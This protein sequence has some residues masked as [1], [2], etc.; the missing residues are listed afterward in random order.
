MGVLAFF[1]AASFSLATAATAPKTGGTLRFSLEKDI[2]NVNPFERASSVNKDV[3]SL[4]FECLLTSDKDDNLR[5][6]LATAWEV[7]KKGDEYAF[8]LRK[9]VKFHNGKEM[10]AEDVL[11]SINYA[12]DPKNAAYGRDALLP[13]ASVSAAD[14]SVLRITLREPYVPF[15]A[16]LTS[17]Q[18]FPIVPQGS[19]PPERGKMALYPPGT[20]P[21]MMVDYKPNQV[22]AFKRFDQYW[23]KGLPY[24]EAVHFR[25]VED[26]TVRLTALR[27]G[28]FDVV[29]RVAYPEAI[30]IQKGEF[31]DISLKVADA[32]GYIAPV[33]NTERPPFDDPRLRRAAL[34]AIDKSKILDGVTWGLGA[35][36]DQRMHRESRWFVTLPDRK[37]DIEKARALLREAGYPNGIRIKGQVS[38][39]KRD[40]DV[41]QLL[42]SQLREANIQM[43]LEVRDFAKH[44]NDLRDGSFTLSMSAGSTNI[45]PDAVYYRNF[46]TEKTELRISNYPRYS[47]PRVDRLLE[48]GRREADFQRRH[49]IY[50]EVV[51][52]LLEDVPEIALGFTPYVFAFRSHVHGF[53][54]SPYGVFYYGLGGLAMTWMDR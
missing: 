16:T 26:A 1:L 22:I 42:Q 40:Q 20:G 53:D 6:S 44:M 3:G 46:H 32:S 7:S 47:N 14:A 18:T 28:D 29:E 54:V 35:V 9:G 23:Q 41:M 33:F 38:R 45:D 37:R 49:Q 36:G 12:R 19:V 25:P 34:Y 27:A 4:A 39:T 52:I 15:L 11:W 8:T 24:L 50:K 51:E 10:T 31:K 43:E 2:V 30:R 5:P 17:F 48:E 13:I 21:F